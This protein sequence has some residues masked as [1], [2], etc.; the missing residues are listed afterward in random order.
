MGLDN[1]EGEL[2]VGDNF[3]RAN[4]T[5]IESLKNMG[6][7][8]NSVECGYKHV[9][10]KSSLGKV[11]TWGWGSKGQL[12]H[13]NLNSENTPKPL[14]VSQSIKMKIIQIQA[15]YRCSLILSEDKKVYWFGTAGGINQQSIPLR[16]IYGKKVWEII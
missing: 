12:G 6:E 13:G 2:G 1:S 11:Y 8:I 3:P 16:L 14:N 5:L 10:C 15:G 7:K 4:P 9:I